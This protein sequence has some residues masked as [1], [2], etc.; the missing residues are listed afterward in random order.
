MDVT[1]RIWTAVSG[2]LSIN[3]G[4]EDTSTNIKSSTIKQT[5]AVIRSISANIVTASAL[6]VR[7]LSSDGDI[8]SAMS[9]PIGNF[10]VGSALYNAYEQNCFDVI[11][12]SD[13]PL[14]VSIY[15]PPV[16]TGGVDGD[17]RIKVSGTYESLQ[18]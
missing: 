16:G 6:C 11:E 1:S 15:K 18:F 8:I 17:V 12:S 10:P 14:T 7:V 3:A 9:T 2:T 4:S 5:P 13:L